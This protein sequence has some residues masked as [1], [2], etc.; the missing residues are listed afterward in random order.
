MD[1]LEQIGIVLDD[2]FADIDLPMATFN[3]DEVGGHEVVARGVH[4][5]RRIGFQVRLEPTWECQALEDGAIKELYWGRA[6]ISS[7]GEESDRFLRLLGE[8]Y[9][10]SIDAKK[11]RER[12]PFLAVSLSGNPAYLEKRPVKMKLFYES[13]IEE[14]DADFYINVDVQARRVEFREKDTD[15]RRGIILSLCADP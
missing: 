11:M 7:I 6:E 5:G 12:T 3:R 2:G 1:E 4:Q 13:E 10:T 14:R 8:L 15:Y 9:G